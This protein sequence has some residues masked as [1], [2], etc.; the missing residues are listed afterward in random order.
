MKI[1]VYFCHCG[2]NIADKISGDEV[3]RHL[4]VPDTEIHYMQIPF[5]CSDE[6]KEILNADL[7]AHRPDR[8]VVAACSPRDHELTFMRA[9][10][11][12]E[13]NPYLMQM[14][15]IREQVAWVTEDPGQATAKAITQ[16]RAA[17]RRVMLQE[18]LE[19]RHIDVSP[20]V[21]IIGAGSA[22]IKAALS[23]AEAG[24]KVTLVEKTA[25]IGGAAVRYEEVFP[26]MECAPCMLEPPMGELLHGPLADRIEL[27]LLSEVTEVVGFYGN[28]TVTIQQRA[29]GVD[30]H[31]C[32]GCGECVTPCPVSVPNEV[33][34]KRDQQKAIAFPYA[35]ALPN[36]PFI[37]WDACVRS[38]GDPCT[39]CRDACPVE[40]TVLLEE[41][42]RQHTRRVGAIVLATGAEEYDAH[43]I[44]QLRYGESPDIYTGLEFERI[45]ASNGPTNGELRKADG[46]APSTVAIV[47]C[48]GSLD[49][50]HKKYCSGVCCQY[51]FK[52]NHLIQKKAPGTNVVHLFREIVVPGKDDSDLYMHAR[53]ASTST[54]LRYENID[55]I[56]VELSNGKPQICAT[57]PGSPEQR[58]ES[59]MVVL[60]PAIVPR[61]SHAAI[62]GVLEVSTDTGG[63]F[64]ELHDRMD[65]G[66][67]KVKGVFLAGA[68]QAPMNIQQAVNQS[69]AATGY[70]LSG[71]VEG[72]K[73]EVSP[74]TAHVNQDRC[75]GCRVCGSVC[76]YNAISFDSSRSVSEVNDV[77][78]Q[79]CGTCVA[80]C[81]ASA[82]EGKHFT[83]AMIMAEIDEVLR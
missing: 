48:V 19:V 49:A 82:I 73:L 18:P 3:G 36:A 54:F 53:H 1:A 39:L 31:K 71:L 7:L 23:F 62:A 65:S 59:D 32:I 67:S 10:E 63:F 40:E 37:D 9:L 16:I 33:N 44:P 24:R 27:M 42:A 45:L 55:Q 6:G 28:Y 60:C 76:P 72:R 5:M 70:V 29:R 56:R 47:H 75:S 57:L 12:A 41:A 61:S 78:C 25:A 77:L 15:N 22:G 43:R 2:S 51:A 34:F 50:R 13:I 38:H 26:H 30:A 83:N 52:F 68:C 66:K 58:I 11:R 69:L 64:E 35:G 21:L 46:T 74:V 14:V 8:V 79:G 80:A 81:P 4:D 17:I 20:D